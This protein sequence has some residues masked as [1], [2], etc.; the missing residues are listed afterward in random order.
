MI[1]AAVFHPDDLENFDPK[2][3]FEDLEKILTAKYDH[4]AVLMMTVMDGDKVVAVLGL[5]EQRPGSCE[6]WL[7]PCSDLNKYRVSF[8]KM[9][10]KL[11]QDFVM[12]GYG[13]RRVEMAVKKDWEMGLLWAETLGFKFSHIAR[14]YAPGEDHVVFY[15]LRETEE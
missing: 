12:E 1:R 4:P 8:I 2:T 5:N 10:R 9:C 7:L 14:E 3:K 6:L 11:I 15:K 13:Y